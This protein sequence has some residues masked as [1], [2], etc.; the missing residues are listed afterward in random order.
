MSTLLHRLDEIDA[1]LSSA[2]FR[3]LAGFL[4]NDALEQEIGTRSGDIASV[5]A[6]SRRIY[7]AIVDSCAYHVAYIN[8]FL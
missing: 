4:A 2:Q 8:R 7:E 5:V 6:Q 3:E 1:R